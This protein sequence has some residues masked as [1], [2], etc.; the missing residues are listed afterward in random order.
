MRRSEVIAH[1]NLKFAEDHHETNVHFKATT[2]MV[3]SIEVYLDDPFIKDGSSL[4]L[5]SEFY[6]ELN[7]YLLGLGLT[8]PEWNSTKTIFSVYIDQYTLAYETD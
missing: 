5:K 3:P 8:N 6:N 1:L 7:K 2:L 4:N